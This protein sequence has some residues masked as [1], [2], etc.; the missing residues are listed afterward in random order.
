M[1]NP[2][3]FDYEIPNNDEFIKEYDNKE[4][5][6]DEVLTEEQASELSEVT[7]NEQAKQNPK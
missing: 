3:G 7:A 2:L 6:S 5:E 4:K 1:D